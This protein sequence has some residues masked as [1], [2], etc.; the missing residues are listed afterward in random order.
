MHHP[1]G[2]LED[3]REAYRNEPGGPNLLLDPGTWRKVV[4]NE[5]KL[6]RIV[7][8]AAEPSV[9]APGLMRALATSTAAAARDCR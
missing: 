7:C 4:T 8:T 6:R 2:A 1:C 5:E 9:P 3:I